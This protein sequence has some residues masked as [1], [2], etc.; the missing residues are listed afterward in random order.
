MDLKQATE[1]LNEC[2]CGLGVIEHYGFYTTF[3]TDFHIAEVLGGLPAVKDT[4]NR[5]WKEWKDDILYVTEM[6]VVICWRMDNPKIDDETRKYYYKKKCEMD[7]YIF[8]H[9]KD[10]ELQYFIRFTD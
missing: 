1:R 4:F 6:Y 10:E 5:A 3:Y 9:Y 8:K 2:M 7:D